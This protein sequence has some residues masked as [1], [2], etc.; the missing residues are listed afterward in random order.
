MHTWVFTLFDAIL[1]KTSSSTFLQTAILFFNEVHKRAVVAVLTACADALKICRQAEAY[2]CSL[3]N[4]IKP[5]EF[6]LLDL[7]KI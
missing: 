1:N 6:G 5:Y 7:T 2:T 4:L 3:T